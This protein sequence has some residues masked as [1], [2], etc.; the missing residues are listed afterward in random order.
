MQKDSPSFVGIDIAEN[1]IKQGKELTE[2][3]NLDVKY[4]VCEAEKL[5]FEK[6]S[7]DAVTACQCIWYFDEEKLLHEVHKVLKKDG[8]FAILT[9]S[10]LPEEDELCAKSEEL[11]LKY[12]PNWTGA[13]YKRHEVMPPEW[14]NSLFEVKDLVG[15]DVNVPFTRKTW[16]GRMKACRGVGASLTDE[17]IKRFEKEHLKMLNESAPEEFNILHYVTMIILKKIV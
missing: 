10:W 1:Q 2:R 14:L 13:G 5:P 16:N 4:F 9:M 15:F 11:V 3:A 12:S 8:L 6:E 17:E 7:F